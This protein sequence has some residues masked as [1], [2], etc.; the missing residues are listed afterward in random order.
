MFYLSNRG[1]FPPHSFR[2]GDQSQ[3]VVKGLKVSTLS[4]VKSAY[5]KYGGKELFC[6]AK[7]AFM[8]SSIEPFYIG[9]LWVGGAAL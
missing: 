8:Q 2:P 4:M 3:R 6:P 1:Y 5:V 9:K 7:Y